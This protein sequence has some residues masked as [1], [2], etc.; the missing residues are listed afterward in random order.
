[1]KHNPIMKKLAILAG[2]IVLGGAPLKAESVKIADLDGLITVVN[3]PGLGATQT[4]GARIGLWNGTT[5]TSSGNIVGSGYFDNDL[6]EL[7]AG[8]SSASN[9]SGFAAGTLLAL[10]IYN[11]VSTADFST[12]V[13]RAI[14]T[15]ASWLMPTLAFGTAVKATF[16]LTAN[17]TAVVGGYSYNGGNQTITLVPEPSTGALMALS[18]VGM[19]ALRRLRKV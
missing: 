1:M 19:I 18:A 4:I 7:S 11:D 6:K 8:I 3:I 17:T 14:L 5:F 13:N 12:T 9:P 2:T 10:A 15:D 16:G